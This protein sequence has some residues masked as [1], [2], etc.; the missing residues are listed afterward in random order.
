M[1][2]TTPDLSADN[3]R[4]ARLTAAIGAQV[5]GV[6]LRRP[7]DAFAFASIEAALVE[8]QVLFFRGQDLDEG[9]QRAFAERFGAL[10][11]YP[12]ARL[13]GREEEMTYIEDSAQ[14]PPAADE[15]HTDISWVERPPRIAVLNARVIPEFGGDTM[16]ASLFAAYQALSPQMRAFCETLQVRHHPGPD[17]TDKIRRSPNFGPAFADRLAEAF[18]PAV[19]PLVRTHPVSGRQ[20]LFVSGFMDEVEGLSR[21]ESDL[22]LG[23]LKSLLDDPNLQVRWRWRPHDLV[24]W[25][26]ASTNHRA[27]SDHFPQHR[28]MRRCTVDGDR[29]FF[30]RALADEAS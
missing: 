17:F 1:R 12:V 2:E 8:H 3:L 4:I 24:I 6:D 29:P 9:Q 18:P 25:D 20:A 27:L 11:V 7:L 21:R 26:E 10:G 5:D 16:W 13:A 30:R 19:H 14:S 15:W 23:Y 28:K 22:L